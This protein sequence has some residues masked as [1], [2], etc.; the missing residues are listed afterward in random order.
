[1]F[2]HVR[3]RPAEM[4]DAVGGNLIIKPISTFVNSILTKKTDAKWRKLKI[5]ELS[6]LT[7]RNPE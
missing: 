4:P 7:V 5:N 1:M 6:L 2:K 3:K